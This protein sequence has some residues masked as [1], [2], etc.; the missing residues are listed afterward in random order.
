MEGEAASV[1]EYTG[2]VHLSMSKKPGC[3]SD[4]I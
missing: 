1:Y 4:V 3:Q 2:V